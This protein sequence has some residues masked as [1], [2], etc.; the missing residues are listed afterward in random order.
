MKPNTHADQDQ[1]Q[2][3][4]ITHTKAK[5]QVK[6]K[7][8]TKRQDKKKKNQLRHTLLDNELEDVEKRRE[9]RLGTHGLDF[10]QELIAEAPQTSARLLTHQVRAAAT[11][12]GT[13]DLLYHAL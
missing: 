11:T 1:E 10:R 4:A 2:I 6:R 12:E 9:G 8:T 5:D 3:K 13:D 7:E